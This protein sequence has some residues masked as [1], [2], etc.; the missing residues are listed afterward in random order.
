MLRTTSQKYAH[1]VQAS[2]L[3]KYDSQINEINFSPIFFRGSY[4]IF[5]N[6]IRGNHRQIATPYFANY[7]EGK[8][9]NN[10]LIHIDT[11]NLKSLL[12]NERQ[13]SIELMLKLAKYHLNSKTIKQKNISK[14]ITPQKK[15]LF[16]DEF[17]TTFFNQPIIILC[18]KFQNGSY[19]EF[20]PKVK[21]KFYDL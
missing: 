1:F 17:D 14:K 2:S 18:K 20:S 3:I 15:I 4:K 13:K 10:Q 6:M 11:D 8:S 5:S 7:D 9:L 12:S 16:P 19:D 21:T